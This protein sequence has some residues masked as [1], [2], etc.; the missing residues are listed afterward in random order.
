[1]RGGFLFVH[2]TACRSVP[3]KSP[4]GG[5]W[6]ELWWSCWKAVCMFVC[7]WVYCGFATVRWLRRIT[8]VKLTCSSVNINAR[9]LHLSEPPAGR[10]QKNA[11]WPL[12]LLMFASCFVELCYWFQDCGSGPDDSISGTLIPWVVVTLATESFFLI[13]CIVETYYC[14]ETWAVLWVWC[15]VVLCVLCWMAKLVWLKSYIICIQIYLWSQDCGSV[16]YTYIPL[17]SRLW[18][19]T[20]LIS[21]LVAVASAIVGIDPYGYASDPK[22][23]DLY[24]DPWSQDCGS[25]SKPLIQRLWIF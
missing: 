20:S 15:S 23:V 5:L 14:L 1:M 10:S 16:N 21:R 12:V 6:T 17:I 24:D 8:A 3:S 25:I 4:F 18:I 13:A 2:K 7:W 19:C 9:L 22:T 11:G